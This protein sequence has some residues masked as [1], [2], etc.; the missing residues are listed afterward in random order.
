MEDLVIRLELEPMALG[1]DKLTHI[2]IEVSDDKGGVSRGT[3][4]YRSCGVRCDVHPIELRKME[5]GGR[6]HNICGRIFDGKTEHQGF[7][8]HLI[9]CKKKSPK[10]MQFAFDRI[11]PHAEEVKDLFLKGEYCK[12]ADLLTSVVNE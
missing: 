10:K 1:L 9:D 11:S 4:E 3:G 8:V 12:I 5:Y 2:E 7:F 6:A